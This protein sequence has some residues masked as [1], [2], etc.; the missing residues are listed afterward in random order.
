MTFWPPPLVPEFPDVTFSPPELVQSTTPLVPSGVVVGV[1]EPG[2]G[3]VGGPLA[4]ETSVSDVVHS[5]AKS[6]GARGPM[7]FEPVTFS[8]CGRTRHG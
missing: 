6:A 3:G 2:D 8:W 1:Q 7:P 4:D 5:G